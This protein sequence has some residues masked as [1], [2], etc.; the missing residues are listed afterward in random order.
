MRDPVYIVVFKTP[1]M[2][3]LLL[4]GGHGNPRTFESKALLLSLF[5][6]PPISARILEILAL[7]PYAIRWDKTAKD[8]NKLLI[9]REILTVTMKE[10]KFKAAL[11]GPSIWDHLHYEIAEWYRTDK[12]DIS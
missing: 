7:H 1:K 5:V 8:L 11:I 3:D 4:I 10:A 12:F 6:I 9:S 2:G